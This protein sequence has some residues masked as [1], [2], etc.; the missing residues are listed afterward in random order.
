MDGW[1]ILSFNGER[2]RIALDPTSFEIALRAFRSMVDSG[3]H[4]Q[5]VRVQ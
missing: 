2:W 4:A 5:L 3:L 1:L